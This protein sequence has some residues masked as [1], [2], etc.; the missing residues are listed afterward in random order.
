MVAQE[1]AMWHANISMTSLDGSGLLT[2]VVGLADVS[3]DWSTFNGSTVVGGAHG[4]WGPIVSGSRM[5][6]AW[7]G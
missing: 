7:R 5:S 2:S 1:R 4:Q 6:I 3:V